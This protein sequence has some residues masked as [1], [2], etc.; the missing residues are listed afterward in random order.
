MIAGISPEESNFM[1]F[2]NDGVIKGCRFRTLV[3]IPLSRKGI[4]LKS[5]E[6]AGLKLS[7]LGVLFQ[8]GHKVSETLL[9]AKDFYRHF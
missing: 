3:Y 5:R 6:S 1:D 4:A 2:K 9:K 8:P 7:G